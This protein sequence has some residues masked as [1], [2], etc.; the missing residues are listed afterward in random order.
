MGLISDCRD[1]APSPLPPAPSSP[2]PSV[3]G[4]RA[5]KPRARALLLLQ[6][7]PSFALLFP[8]DPYTS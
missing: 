2:P 6:L 3:A 4:R 5:F 8:L 1:E 7:R